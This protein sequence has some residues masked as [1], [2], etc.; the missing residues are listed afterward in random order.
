MKTS[1]R[2]VSVPEYAELKDISKQAIYSKIKRGQLEV[3]LVNNKK[4]LEIHDVEKEDKQESI[5]VKLLRYK[6]KTTK[7][8]NK[9]LQKEL[10]EAKAEI[11]QARQRQE[12][13]EDKLDRILESFAHQIESSNKKKNDV[14]DVKI[15]PKKK[16]KRKK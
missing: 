10:K 7:K 14:I 15:K 9:R 5:T 11:L 6:N 4:M 12:R 13:L 3:K 8:E 1:T 16:K 2:L